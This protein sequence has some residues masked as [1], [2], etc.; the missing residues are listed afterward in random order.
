MINGTPIKYRTYKEEK[1]V[2]SKNIKFD[3]PVAENIN[4]TIAMIN[5]NEKMIK[6][7]NDNIVNLAVREFLCNYTIGEIV[8]LMKNEITGI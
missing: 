6:A 1:T 7:N 2:I 4:R 8:E 3:K 5:L